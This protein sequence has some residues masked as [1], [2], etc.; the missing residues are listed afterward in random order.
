M[1]KRPYEIKVRMNENELS[2][3]SE[4]VAKTD[5]NREDS[6][7]LMIAGYTVQEVPKDYLK[8][9]MEMARICSTLRYNSMN[10]CLTYEEKATLLDASKE[11]SSIAA[12]MRRIYEPYYKERKSKHD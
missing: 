9:S 10:T 2:H 11:L 8:F 12:E 4:M 6:L 7:R 1:R 5:F 3:L